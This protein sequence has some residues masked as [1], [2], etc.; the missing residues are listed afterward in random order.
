MIDKSTTNEII[1][2]HE[3]HLKEFLG[4]DEIPKH[5]ITSKEYRE[6]RNSFMKKGQSF[7]EQLCNAS[8]KILQFS[9]SPEKKI[10]MEEDLKISHLET[11][12]SGVLAC[13]VIFP[14]LIMLLGF[15]F[16]I[17]VLNSMYVS[18]YFIFGGIAGVFIL[19][20]IPSYYANDWRMRSSNQMVLC[21]FYVVTY[22]RHT[23]NLERAIYFA[24]Q[25][26][27]PPL[28]L[29]LKKILWDVE[30][31]EYKSIKDSLEI[32]LVTWKRW[33]KEFV[34]AF[35][36]IESSL[37][38]PSEEQRQN[39]LDKALDRI[40]EET[41]EKMT[42]YAQELKS[43]ITTLHML[44]IIL[45][46]LGLVILPLIVSFSSDVAWWQISLL[47]NV[48]LP[49]VVYFMGKN[50]LSM[51]PT[52]YGDSNISEINLGF[53]KYGDSSKV[54][55]WFLF[56]V[57]FLGA[58]SPIL[59]HNF[60]PDFDFSIGKFKLIG[61]QM[62]SVQV[63]EQSYEVLKGP[64]GLGA[65]LISLLFPL[66]VALSIGWYY[67]KKSVKLIKIRDATKNLEN[68]FSDTLFQL[69]NRLADG[70]PAEV[71]LEKVAKV[72][73]DTPTGDFFKVVTS[74]IRKM[75]LSV[76]QAIFNPQ[77]GAILIYPSNL[78]H[79]SMKVLVQSL[80]KGPLIASQAIQSV[81]VYIKEIHRVNE[82]LND[83]MTEIISDMKSQ[84][85]FL[86]PC[87]AGIVMGITAMMNFIL[88][89]LSQNIKCF[90]AE[91]GGGFY[92]SIK[93]IGLSAGLPTYYFQFVVGMYVV[94]I[95]YILTILSN[96]IENGADNLNEQYSLGKNMIRSAMIYTV[97][98]GI[99]MI[100][101]T[102]IAGFVLGKA[103]ATVVGC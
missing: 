39:V 74:N 41:S 100:S 102:L 79:S 26:L 18:F 87:I 55:A 28:S 70:I 78:I 15:V 101:F 47:Y 90:G 32:Y 85:N 20:K 54:F 93:N 43:P 65:T 103:G 3:S 4:I 35:H 34:E 99:M 16:S 89:E 45:P 17:F 36:L 50:I 6:F 76:E 9:V 61:Y 57:L 38:E 10:Q 67:K 1:S 19:Q 64:F 59:I 92:D 95:I 31:G 48:A 24:S 40:L 11:T 96:G 97:F 2:H 33:N 66:S 94:E 56:F 53:K 69:S 49:L 51:R 84:I 77:T 21:I 58:L 14:I 73:Q 75:G 23:S 42:H 98:A 91:A 12:P 83:L 7:Y 82:R 37:Y 88:S 8:G 22:L 30:N 5:E 13:S 60:A 80:K 25:H 68:E 63:G 86:T 52:G 62:V 29:D 71:A 72:A 27:T 46:I 81:S 44:G